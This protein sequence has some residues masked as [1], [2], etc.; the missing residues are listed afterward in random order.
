MKKILLAGLLCLLAFASFGQE[1]VE[2]EI[3]EFTRVKNV[4]TSW[5]LLVRKVN[6]YYM[7]FRKVDTFYLMDV[8]IMGGPSGCEVK[9]VI[10]NDWFMFRTFDD[11][12]ITLKADESAI[13]S[14]GGGAFGLAGSTAWGILLTYRVTKEQLELIRKGDV[15]KF[16]LYTSS[17]YIEK[18]V[19]DKGVKHVYTASSLILGYN[20]KQSHT[21][22]WD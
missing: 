9:G 5:A 4:T 15:Y 21:G 6:A 17:G 10:K 8:K 20:V 3:D 19:P 11:S 7:R 13:M 22:Y 2:D 1:I 16:R 14:L 12:I 18:E